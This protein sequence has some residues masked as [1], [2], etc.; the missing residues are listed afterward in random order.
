MYDSDLTLLRGPARKAAEYALGSG[1][2]T[3]CAALC[4]ISLSAH[5]GT[6]ITAE[7]LK[8]YSKNSTRLQ[9]LASSV[10][11]PGRPHFGYR[12]TRHTR[13]RM[14]ATASV[15]RRESQLVNL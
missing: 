10:R 3:D 1:V 8:I 7:I 6:V 11:A 9:F 13:Q 14:Q 12:N 5:R 4:K 15:L 2:F